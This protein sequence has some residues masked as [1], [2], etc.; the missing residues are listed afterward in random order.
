[1]SFKSISAAILSPRA[2][3]RLTVDC[4]FTSRGI[5]ITAKP[6]NEV[7]PTQSVTVV[8]NI[9]DD[10]AGSRFRALSRIG[11]AA[12]ERPAATFFELADYKAA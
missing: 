4:H 6:R 2:T 11:L 3:A 1:M 8:R 9:D 10:C 12:P 5:K 7:K